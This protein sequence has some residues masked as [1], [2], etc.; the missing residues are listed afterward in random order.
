MRRILCGSLVLLLLLSVLSAC[1]KK[2]TDTGSTD[3]AGKKL[4]FELMAYSNP[5]PY[6]PEGD[7][8]AEAIQA[9]LAKAG[10]D[11]KITTLPWTQYKDAVRVDGKGDA[12]LFGWIG[13]NGDPDNFLY[14]HFHSSQSALNI[15]KYKND[16]VDQLL[17]QAQQVSDMSQRSKIYADAQTLIAQ[18]A[19]WVFL[20][21]MND[22][23][24]ARSTVKN[25]KIHPTLTLYDFN[26]IEVEGKKELIYARGADATS[27]DPAVVEDGES[28]KVISQ[29]YDNLVRFKPGTT[30]VMADLATEWNISNDGLTYTFK[31]RPGVKFHDGTDFNADA[32][33]FSIDRQL[34]DDAKK[35][36]PYAD[37]TFGIVKEVKVVDPLTVQIIL[38]E[39]NSPFLA[40][41]A[42]SIA[43]PIVSPTAVQKYGKDYGEHPVGT[44]AFIF[45]KWDKDQQIVLKANPNYWGGAPK[46]E[47][48][49]FKVTAKNE[50]RTDEILAGKVDIMDGIAPSDL[51]RLKGANGVTLLQQPGMNISYMSFR[52]DRAP[53]NDPKVRQAISQLIN[54]E[55][56]VSSLYKGSATLA[57]GALPSWMPGY[58]PNVKP[59]P[60]DVNKAKSLLKEAGYATK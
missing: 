3:T 48:V 37:F 41:L 12:Y 45:E 46:L 49:I 7:K 51:T 17:K 56:I 2:T 19:P 59:L 11:V 57:N 36:W 53:F 40:N 26:K 13:D 43:A 30:E 6:N 16:K 20:S 55:A 60:Y 44:G 33:K 5:R 24:A 27:L 29:V 54:R 39:P 52:T 38:K 35:N 32:V 8:L 21:H 31:L 42:M 1:A 4:S 10:I 25:F 23:V 50:V 14:V 22:Y 15:G 58:A 28:A 9:E 18:D 34:T 47:R